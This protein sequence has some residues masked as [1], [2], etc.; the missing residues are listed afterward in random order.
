MIE[1]QGQCSGGIWPIQ[2]SNIGSFTVSW[3]YNIASNTVQF[4]IQGRFIFLLIS[5]LNCLWNILGEANSSI[6]LT[7]TYISI[8]WSDTTSTMVCI[9]LNLVELNLYPIRIIWMLQCSFPELK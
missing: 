6:N 5:C 9:F 3:R 1:I 4:I 8:G 2:D 7:S